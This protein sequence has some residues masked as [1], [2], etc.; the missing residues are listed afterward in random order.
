MHR[1][2]LSVAKGQ[3]GSQISVLKPIPTLIEEP[4][5]AILCRIAN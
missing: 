4:E 5:L 2:D 1:E 3:S